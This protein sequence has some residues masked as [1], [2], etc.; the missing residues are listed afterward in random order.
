MQPVEISAETERRFVL[1]RQGL[2]PGRRWQGMAGT[3]QAARESEGVQLDP[4]VAVARSQELFLASRVLDYQVGYL[5]QAAYQQRLFFDYGGTLFLYAMEELPYW[6]PRMRASQGYWPEYLREHADVV[7]DVLAALRDRGP[8]GNRDF[9]GNKRINSYRGRKDT[10]LALYALWMTGEVMVH[11]R[12]GFDRVYDLREN[13]VPAQWDWSASEAEAEA[14][15][16][17]KLIAFIGILRERGWAIGLGDYMGKRYTADQARAMLQGSIERGLIA[18]LRVRGVKEPKLVLREDLPLLEALERGEIPAAWRPLGPTTLDE[19]VILAP[20]DIVSAR[21]RAAK[22]FGFEYL[23]EV[24][25]PEEKRRWGYY[26]VAI[27]YGDQL[28][29]RLS[30]RLDRKTATMEL[31][32]LWLEDDALG[33]DPQFA[34]ALA[35]CLRRFQ[36]LHNA[37]AITLDAIHHP[38]LQAMVRRMM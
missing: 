5:D 12:Q 38:A 34:A 26:N 25:V 18:P 21:G 16:A 17:R 8:L 10:A 23:W 37:K 4:L 15:F 22:L 31:R 36:A 9:A 2:W 29:G 6:M 30:P 3:I 7:R 1:G 24:Y 33:H 32:G 13:V 28:V 19:A 35:A 11:H 14:F 27:L 20:L